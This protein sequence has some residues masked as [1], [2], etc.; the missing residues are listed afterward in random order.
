MASLARNRERE[1]LGPPFADLYVGNCYILL[2]VVTNAG[3]GT[4][5][6]RVVTVCQVFW[7]MLEISSATVVIMLETPPKGAE[8]AAAATDLR[9]RDLR[10]ADVGFNE[11]TWTR[12]IVGPSTW[13]G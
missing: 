11:A 12:F 7:W 2:E 8:S 6:S 3:K 1:T 10:V 4:M 9:P 13:R 5:V